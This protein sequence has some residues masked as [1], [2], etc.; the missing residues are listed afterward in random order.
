MI[1]IIIISSSSSSSSIVGIVISTIRIM[2]MTTI[3]GMLIII[4]MVFASA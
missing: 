3:I 1:I 2:R 4:S